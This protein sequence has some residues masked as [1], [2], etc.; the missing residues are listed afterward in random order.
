VPSLRG[1]WQ[2]DGDV[3]EVQWNE[4]C[5]REVSKVRGQG[6]HTL[7]IRGRAER[8]CGLFEGL[9]T[10]Y[11][12]PLSSYYICFLLSPPYLYLGS[13][14]CNRCFRQWSNYKVCAAM[15]MGSVLD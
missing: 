4:I 10:G 12:F 7:V 8:S 5:G 13:S 1:N 3:L 14:V 11:A 2:E 6:V 15:A 9:F